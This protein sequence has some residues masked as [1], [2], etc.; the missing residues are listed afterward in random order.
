MALRCLLWLGE[1]GLPHRRR[2]TT[3][4][5][6]A[7]CRCGK[8]RHLHRLVDLTGHLFALWLSLSQWP[9]GDSHS[10]VVCVFDVQF[11]HGCVVRR[12]FAVGRSSRRMCCFTF[13]RPLNMAR[14]CVLLRLL[15]R[16][17]L[18]ISDIGWFG[19]YTKGT[20]FWQS[21]KIKM[22]ERQVP[23]GGKLLVR[24]GLPRFRQ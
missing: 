14:M 12:A 1:C 6:A 9:Q 13:G 5:S 23:G 8:G 15:R 7:R 2:H 3:L 24:W 22:A 20:V 21:P 19:K 11:S 4:Q 17:I 10:C 18:S 16:H